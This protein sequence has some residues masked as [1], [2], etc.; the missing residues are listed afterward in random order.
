MTDF[1]KYFRRGLSNEFGVTIQNDRL[2]LRV[3]DYDNGNLVTATLVV[4]DVNLGLENCEYCNQPF[5]SRLDMYT[6]ESFCPTANNHTLVKKIKL[7][8]DCFYQNK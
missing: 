6:A 5:S 8:R 1:E 4:T 2:T 3:H 7:C